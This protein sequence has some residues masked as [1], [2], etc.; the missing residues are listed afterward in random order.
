MGVASF[1]DKKFAVVAMLLTTVLLFKNIIMNLLDLV[2]PRKDFDKKV[3]GFNAR[4]NKFYSEIN[5]SLTDEEKRLHKY[6]EQHTLLAAMPPLLVPVYNEIMM[7]LGWI[8][9]FSITFPAGAFFT[10]FANFLRVSIELTGM[11]EYK[12]KDTPKSV[13][14]IG[15]YMDILELIS[16]VSIVVCVYLVVFTSKQLVNVTG[17]ISDEWLYI[18]AFL[19]MHA[20]FLLKYVMGIL[21]DDVPGW[22]TEDMENEKN[23]LEQVNRDNQDLKLLERLERYDPLDLLFEV[24]KKQHPKEDLSGLIVPK[25]L[26]GCD[27]W[28]RLNEAN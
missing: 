1:Y 11:T 23:R 26:E 24:L 8:L 13:M 22:I 6:A 2:Q 4:F 21:I 3:A 27:N 19:A 25:L 14:D 20:I 7:Q 9:F 15:I 16:N 5:S 17:S 18:Y 28:I 10:I 12:K